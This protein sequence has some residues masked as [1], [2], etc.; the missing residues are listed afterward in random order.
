MTDLK[1]ELDNAKKLMGQGKYE[2]ALAL[3][4]NF[5]KKEGL[6]SKDKLSSLILKGKIYTYSQ[7]YEDA[8][9][10]G[11]LAYQMSQE[12]GCSLP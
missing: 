9:K 12:R 1:S 11:E 2:E 5:E 7:H 3:I 4:S 6:S 10:V 8:V